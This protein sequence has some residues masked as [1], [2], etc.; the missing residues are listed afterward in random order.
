MQWPN[1][2]EKTGKP[3]TT[4]TNQ[5]IL[6]AALA[7]A[8]VAFP[9]E[10]ERL[11][12]TIQNSKANYRSEY[13]DIFYELVKIQAQASPEVVS[14]MAQ[15]GLQKA[16]ESFVVTGKDNKKTPLDQAMKED[17][18]TKL[19]T[20]TLHGTLKAP[21]KN[22][23]KLASPH[24]S[25]SKPLLLSGSDAV[26][27]L[28]AWKDYGC[29]EPSAAE[30]ASQ[31]LTME[32]VSS[33]VQNQTFCLLGVTSQMGPTYSLLQLSGTHVIGV[34]RKNQGL[35]DWFTQNA[36]TNT[37]LQL[38]S[39]DLLTQA[40][41]IA[42]WIVETAP[43]N[44]PLAIMPLAY[45]DGEACVRITVAMEAIVGY[46][47]EHWKG[48]SIKLAYLVSPSLPMAIPDA[49]VENMKER[50]EKEGTLSLAK[51]SS[52]FSVAKP[53]TDLWSTTPK[54]KDLNILNGIIHLQGPNYALSKLLQQWRCIS[55]CTTG[56]ALVAAP[57][58][59]ATRTNSVT[60]SD[61]AAAGLEGLNLFLPIVAFDVQP[62]ATLLTAIVLYQLENNSISSLKHPLQ[63]FAHGA[64]HGGY[65]RCPYQVNSLGI[66]SYLLGR[67]VCTPGSSPAESMAPKP[68]EK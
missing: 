44:K 68:A 16:Q 15:A 11:E 38:T 18:V 22:I 5:A 56:K 34:A 12:K 37:T 20:E 43:A 61:K 9:S 21:D 8:K 28:N 31:I 39:A 32:D 35:K 46:V 25:D 49:A 19:E 40:P 63:H 50:Y 67:T 66:M 26:D 30:Q 47:M 57:V 13:R 29:L 1:T 60:H 14:A 64:V 54:E 17:P 27:Q 58:A 10:V 55:A 48:S 6:L 59:P 42:R 51:L 36:H 24:G 62:C 23:L 45:L 3:S 7:A 33:L 2:N 65:W 4:G 41:A 52:S 53:N